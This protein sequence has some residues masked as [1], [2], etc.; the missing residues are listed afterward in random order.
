MISKIMERL[1]LALF[2]VAGLAYPALATMPTANIADGNIVKLEV[3]ST[4]EQIERGLMY[5]TSLADGAGMVFLFHPPRPVKFWM[6]HT[7][8][9]LDM[10]FVLKGRIVKVFENV[11]L[12]GP[13]IQEGVLLIH[14][15]IPG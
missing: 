9:P 12:V 8:I 6:Y 3:A 4:P 14:K 2:L 11:P 7:L 15:K 13:K 1:F 5:R 10:C